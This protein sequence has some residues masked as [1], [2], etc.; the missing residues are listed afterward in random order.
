MFKRAF[1]LLNAMA[2]ASQAAV[3]EK[4]PSNFENATEHLSA[5]LDPQG[6][7][8]DKPKAELIK[9][10]SSRP[11]SISRSNE[12]SLGFRLQMG[13]AYLD[14]ARSI[15]KL[16]M[17][18]QIGKMMELASTARNNALLFLTDKREFASYNDGIEIIIEKCE[19]LLA[20][21][22]L[23]QEQQVNINSILQLAGEYYFNR[24][25]RRSAEIRFNRNLKLIENLYG[26][27]SIEVAKSL[28]WLAK[29]QH[30]LGQTSEEIDS[31]TRALIILEDKQPNSLEHA[32]VLMRLAIAEYYKFGNTNRR[33]KPLMRAIEI[34]KKLPEDPYAAAFGWDFSL[35]LANIRETELSAD[36]FMAVTYPMI[37]KHKIQYEDA[38]ESDLM[39]N[40]Q[41]GSK[42]EI[43]S[44]LEAT[45]AVLEKK[46]GP[47]HYRILYTLELLA[48]S[49]ELNEEKAYWHER[50]LSI[51]KKAF[52][53]DHISIAITLAKLCV[54][55]GDPSKKGKLAFEAI[56]VFQKNKAPRH[57]QAINPLLILGQAHLKSGKVLAA[58]ILLLDAY[59]S[60]LENKPDKIEAIMDVLFKL[61][62]IHNHFDE[63]E[64]ARST[65]EKAVEISASLD[66][67]HPLAEK[68]KRGLAAFN[69][70]RIFEK[71]I[72]ALARNTTQK[73]EPM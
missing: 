47:Q 40:Q 43:K 27:D 7:I 38:M 59:Q 30:E 13:E 54:Y 42:Q 46:Y 29:T 2:A 49:A 64:Q 61:T 50:I 9:L 33:L 35:V 21:Q 4:R 55:E 31:L 62:S 63:R 12:R 45:L 66:K 48:S 37:L 22:D 18:E 36:L 52:G 69:N 3:T 15:A 56:E 71:V 58:K 60:L 67:N 16:P 17:P 70:S 20:S 8:I 10:D 6:N 19:A 73:A 26:S 25:M 14:Q 51:S 24:A 72:K 53:K 57:A 23:S 5:L 28:R 32:R 68:A 65:L 11:L 39:L 44:K 1:L 34:L 41:L